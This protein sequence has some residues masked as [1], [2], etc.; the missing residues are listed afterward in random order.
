MNEL[1]SIVVPIYDVEKYLEKCIESIRHQ[2]YKNLEIILVDDGSPDNC[3]KICDEFTKKD[4]RIKVFHKINGGLSDARNY[5][6]ERANGKYICFVDSDDFVA[7]DYIYTLLGLIKKYKTRVSVVDFEMINGED[8]NTKQICKEVKDYNLNQDQAIRELLKKNSIGDYAWNKMYERSLFS[9]VRFPSGKKMEDMGTTY[10]IFSMIDF[11]AVSKQKKYF[12]VQ[13]KN[14]ILHS[15]NKKFYNDKFYLANERFYYLKEKYPNLK[16]NFHFAFQTC[17][18][19]YPYLDKENLNN[20]EITLKILLKNKGNMI[21][22]INWKLRI[23]YIFYKI[24]KRL[25]IKTFR[26]RLK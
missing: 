8:L 24:S 1:V 26:K 10:K 6:I 4:K 25:F 20:C 15:L 2:T 18:E 23:K 17:M 9:N 12:Y 7:N 22:N 19:C 14:S 3:P 11:I 13:R 21:K 5:G 16:E